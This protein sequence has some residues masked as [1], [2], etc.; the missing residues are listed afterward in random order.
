MKLRDIDRL[1][2]NEREALGIWQRELERQRVQS[3][4]LVASTFRSG[5][6]L[7]ASLVQDATGWAHATFELFNQLQL[8]NQGDDKNLE[9]QFAE[10]LATTEKG[11]FASKIMWPHRNDLARHLGISRKESKLFSVVFPNAIWLFVRRRDLFAQA[12][13]FWRAKVSSQWHDWGSER[14]S[15]PPPY[16]FDGID[17][18]Y[19]ELAAH[20]S[21]W[22]DFFVQSATAH[23]EIVYEEI[24]LDYPAY[25][26]GRFEAAGL[27]KH[28]VYSFPE[29]ARLRR[30]SDAASEQ[31]RE[32]YLEDLFK[33]G[34]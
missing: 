15:E 3:C 32:R 27:C 25:L 10:I 19:R 8:V 12:V 17:A 5:S 22:E 14:Q 29:A 20:E 4:V 31:Y 34:R 24:T 1:K 21:L 16:D 33:L 6:T 23:T 9:R 13:S 30:Q 28:V 11:L 18:C 7:V 2:G 26:T